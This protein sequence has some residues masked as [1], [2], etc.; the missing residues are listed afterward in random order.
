MKNAERKQKEIILFDDSVYYGGSG[1]ELALETLEANEITEVTEQQLFELS[2]FLR[3]EDLDY[4]IQHLIS[5]FD[6]NK[7]KAH[8]AAGNHILVAGSASRWNGSSTGINIYS[9]FESAIDTSPARFGS[10]NIFADCEFDKIWEEDGQLFISGSHHDGSVSVEIRQLSEEGEKL[11][12]EV[13]DCN[14]EVDLY[15]LQLEVMGNI[16]RE[17]DENKFIHDLWNDP[18]LCPIPRYV[19]HEWQ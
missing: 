9:D 13:S 11:F 8:S 10:E 1:K 4:E 2:M 16:Y 3:D 14:G 12:F 17:G 19:E 5:W 6:G 7:S 15:D 18:D